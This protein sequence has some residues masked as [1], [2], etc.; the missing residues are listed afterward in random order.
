MNNSNGSYI[1][2]KMSELETGDMFLLK[3]HDKKPYMWLGLEL[4]SCKGI[5]TQ[6]FA[7][8][9]HGLFYSFVKNE[10]RKVHWNY[11]IYKLITKKNDNESP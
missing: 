8:Y 5:R 11:T 1:V 7:N 6:G 2:I 10:K 4:C 3:H 9:S